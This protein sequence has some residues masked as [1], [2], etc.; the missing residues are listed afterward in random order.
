[1][2]CYCCSGQ[3][4]ENCCEPYL[5]GVKLPLTAEELMRSRYAAYCTFSIDYII[6]T[7][8]ISTRKHYSKASLLQWAQTCKFQSLAIIKKVAG[9]ETDTTGKV[10]FKAFYLN[11]NNKPEVHHEY[12]NFKKSQDQWFFVDG[13]VY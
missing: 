11:E 9:T 6:N 1:M 3:L 7:T 5:N 13:I 12:S 10:E 4:Y 8:H 2:L